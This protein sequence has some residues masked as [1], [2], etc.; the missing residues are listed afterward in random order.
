MQGNGDFPSTSLKEGHSSQIHTAI[1]DFSSLELRLLG[2]LQQDWESHYSLCS[3]HEEISFIK[4][5]SLGS[6][7]EPDARPELDIAVHV[8]KEEGQVVVAIHSPYWMVNKTGRLLQYKADDIHRKH[9]KDYDMPL[10][11][12]FKPRNFLQNNKVGK[13][14]KWTFS[15][16]TD[17]LSNFSFCCFQIRL[18][19]SE[20]ELSDDFSID[21]VGS[22]GD[23]KCK[24]RQKDYMVTVL[25]MKPSLFNTFKVKMK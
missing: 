9:P 16:F 11:F 19:I 12:S 6:E 8:K 24:G 25:S 5:H 3:D 17:Q 13:N 23:V 14:V 10:L 2:Y 20:S 21:T 4:F 1:M 18:M 7:E 15:C 22:Y